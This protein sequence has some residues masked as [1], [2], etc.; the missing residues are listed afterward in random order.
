[1]GSIF[2]YSPF[3]LS[4]DFE[5]KKGENMAE[6]VANALQSVD[7]NQNVILSWR[8][9]YLTRNHYHMLLKHFPRCVIK[10]Y[11]N[12]FRR[13]VGAW[14]HRSYVNEFE[15]LERSAMWDAFWGRLGKHPL[16]K[17]GWNI[18]KEKTS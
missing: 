11:V 3:T 16:Y 2:G 1:M 4:K 7:A 15:L 6:S 12:Q 13:T 8:A 10:E 14:I 17:P 18:E 9:Y 5:I